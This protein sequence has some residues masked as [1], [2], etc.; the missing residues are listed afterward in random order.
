M[1]AIADAALEQIVSSSSRPA[2]PAPVEFRYSQSDSFVAVLYELGATLLVSTYQANKLLA[3]RASGQ[4]LSTLVR[5]F[6]KPMGLAVDGSRLA[7]GTRKEV[8]FLRNA[9]DIAPQI[10]PAGMHDACYLPRMSHVTGD[11]GI[12]EI[13]WATPHLQTRSHNGR[14]EKELWIVSTRFS[15]LATLDPD[16]SFVPRW[17]PPFI[18]A[19][20]AE[21]R[22]HLNGLAI[23]NGQP[24]FVTALG[25]TDVRDGWRAEKARG[26]CIIDISGEE[27]VARG[28]CMPHSPRWHDGKLWV[29]DSGTGGVVLVDSATGK[30]ETIT[31]LPGFTRG[32]AFAGTYAFVGLS[33]IRPTSAM[34][35]V[36]LADR[37]DELRCGIAVV[38]LRSGQTSA[39][40]EFQTAVEEIFDVQLL[41]GSRFP[42]VVGF[43][44]DAL[45]HTFVIPPN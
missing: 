8:W 26:G 1:S 37:R 14:G 33:K 38:D 23:A 32:L 30:R 36:P 9:A 3:V 13:A 42:E 22:C 10:E 19:I 41:A 16:Y 4:G 18:S 45:H 2:P 6:D 20:A 34:D 11:I 43:Q 35:G 25:T 17:R 27:F 31:Q 12:H 5:T 29:L 24:R 15:C 39:F 28:L 7:V 44:K 21:D 40:L